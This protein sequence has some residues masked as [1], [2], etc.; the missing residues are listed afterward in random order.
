MEIMAK[1]AQSNI[2]PF[3][4]PRADAEP[5]NPRWH[6]QQHAKI[7][8]AGIFF[9]RVM[10]ADEMMDAFTNDSVLLTA[11]YSGL[12]YVDA[13]FAAPASGDCLISSSGRFRELAQLFV[14]PVRTIAAPS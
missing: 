7:D 8:A 4:G 13:V 12:R 5:V 11:S 2:Q 14:Q 1:N 3:A 9:L 10:A 6:R